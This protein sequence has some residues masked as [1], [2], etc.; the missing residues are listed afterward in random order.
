MISYA[1]AKEDV[2]LWRCLADRVS[3][4]EGFYVDVGANDPEIDSVTKVFYDHG[5]RGINLEPSLHWHGRLVDQRPRDVNLQVAASETSGTIAFHDIEGH[6][7][8]TV[9][10]RFADR[11]A[12]SGFL[13]NSYSVPAVTLAEV[14]EAH[15]PAT[16][17][18]LKIDVEG[19]EEA[20][21]RGM[22][23]L[24]FRPWIV[25]VE[26]VE[27]NRLESPTFQN[28]EALITDVGYSFAFTDVLNRYYVADERSEL[29]RE[30]SLPVDDYVPAAYVRR[31]LELE[32]RL[33]QT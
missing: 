17:H 27:P 4:E 10:E 1:Q 12:S 8:G 14:C 20:V 21:L 33:A 19:H 11:H 9:V 23:F 22:D 24:R 18:F 32:A 5:W 6:Q 15:A 31:I 7:L 28:W 13:K 16:I 29:L 26:A 3:Y 30:F 2:Y 25:I